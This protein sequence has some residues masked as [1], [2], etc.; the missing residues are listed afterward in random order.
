MRRLT[1]RSRLSNLYWNMMTRCYNAQHKSYHRYGGRGIVVCDEWRGHKDV[2][3]SWVLQNGWHPHLQLDRRNND[4]GYSPDNCRFV[5]RKTQRANYSA[6]TEPS[7]A[8]RRR[9]ENA[10]ERTKTSVAV[11]QSWTTP[12]RR[13]KQTNA[14]KA[15]WRDPERMERGREEMRRRWRDP[16]FRA[17]VVAASKSRATT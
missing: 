10:S 8:Q 5:D 2:F 12:S 9:Y 13:Q 16:E 3:I 15:A 14:M 6:S 4:E 11:A 17:R 7:E 1:D